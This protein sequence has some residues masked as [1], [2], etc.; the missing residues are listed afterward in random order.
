MCHM[1]PTAADTLRAVQAT[2]EHDTAT[3]TPAQNNGCTSRRRPAGQLKLGG[4]QDLH[5]ATA[6]PCVPRADAA[7]K[8]RVSRDMCD[9]QGVQM[10]VLNTQHATGLKTGDR[11]FGGTPTCRSDDDEGAREDRTEKRITKQQ[12][13]GHHL[14]MLRLSHTASHLTTLPTN[15]R[16]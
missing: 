9:A 12:K 14:Q 6:H 7:F 4:T 2:V 15:V 1:Q 3:K 16:I 8:I 10:A 11:K 13:R 5:T